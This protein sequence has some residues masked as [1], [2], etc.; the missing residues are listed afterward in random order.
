[1]TRED[2][3]PGMVVMFE[4]QLINHPE[5]WMRAIGIVTRNERS[6]HLYCLLNDHN[7]VYSGKGGIRG[8]KELPW[9]LECNT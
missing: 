5:M 4:Y 7:C 3:K 1:M 6:L 2:L 8:I 9:R